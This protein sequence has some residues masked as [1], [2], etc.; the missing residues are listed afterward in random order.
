[1]LSSPGEAARTASVT[2]LVTLSRLRHGSQRAKAGSGL[3]PGLSD[4]TRK[5]LTRTR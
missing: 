2:A 4:T 5:L 1:M 3:A